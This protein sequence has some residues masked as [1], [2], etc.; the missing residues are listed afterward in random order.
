MI[1]LDPKPIKELG[2]VLNI[3]PMKKNY[4]KVCSHMLRRPSVIINSW[5]MVQG[6]E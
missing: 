3:W 5:M 2:K 1:M 4:V 6:E